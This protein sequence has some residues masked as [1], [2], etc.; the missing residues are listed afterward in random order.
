MTSSVY[1]PCVS[2]YQAVLPHTR[3]HALSIIRIS[4]KLI[5]GVSGESNHPREQSLGGYRVDHCP[6]SVLC[7][8]ILSFLEQ[9]QTYQMLDCSQQHNYAFFTA[10]LVTKNG[11]KNYIS[12][13]KSY[14]AQIWNS[15]WIPQNL[16][17]KPIST[18]IRLGLA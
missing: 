1:V 17:L 2:S 13:L 7:L 6:S 9:T 12:H 14:R 18:P 3:S 5:F 8:V 10:S 15:S 11:T 16:L 4:T